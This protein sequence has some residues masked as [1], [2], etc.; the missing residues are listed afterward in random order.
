MGVPAQVLADGYFA[1]STD[2][3]S[4]LCMKYLDITRL[5]DRVILDNLAFAWVKLHTPGSLPM[6]KRPQVGQKYM[7]MLETVRYTAV[8]SANNL[9]WDRMLSGR[10]FI[11]SRRRADQVLS[12]E[13]HQRSL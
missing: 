7:A 8:P 13:V 4:L 11:Y 5:F 3:T 12:P 1:A 2:S 6:L 10:S 9:T